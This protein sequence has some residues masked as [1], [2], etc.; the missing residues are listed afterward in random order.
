MK[1]INEE[2]AILEFEPETCC[3]NCK[4][5]KKNTEVLYCKKY[6]GKIIDRKV[7]CKGCGLI[8]KSPKMT[9]ESSDFFY[10]NLY[11]DYMFGSEK[12]DPHE[13][14]YNMGRKRKPELDLFSKE[15]INAK[16]PPLE[17]GCSSGGVL[18]VLE[19]INSLSIGIDIDSQSIESAK[20]MG[21][22]A[23]YINLFDLP[24]KSRDFILMSHTVEHLEDISI[25]MEKVSKV[26][27]DGGHLLI[28]VPDSYRILEPPHL[29]HEYCFSRE[30]LKSTLS[31]YRLKEE[32][33]IYLKERPDRFWGDLIML[34]KKDP[35]MKYYKS[36]YSYLPFFKYKY[37]LKIYSIINP[38]LMATNTKSIARK[39]L[40][41]SSKKERFEGMNFWCWFLGHRGVLVNGH[42]LCERC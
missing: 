38:F 5:L 27:V 18:S 42:A 3:P 39:F 34:F 19:E 6:K 14:H 2:I 15:I 13:L 8:Y 36:N 32:M 33:F 10:N 30:T 29:P 20:K 23:E 22:N 25:M 7:L 35:K 1:M 26:L 41:S 37:Y 17:I 24:N 9:S 40:R 11:M 12:V 21:V 4:G 16:Y 31:R 28:F